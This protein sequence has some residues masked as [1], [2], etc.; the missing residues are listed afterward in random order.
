MTQKQHKINIP[1]EILFQ[2]LSG[3][4]VVLNLEN[5]H[6]YGL[7]EVGTRMWALLAEHGQLAPVINIL[8]QEYDVDE[9]RLRTDL[10]SLIDDL[11]EQGLLRIDAA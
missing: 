8:L 3:E 4:A 5:G 10:Q 6:Y 9:D 11:I 2:E 1:P 7:D